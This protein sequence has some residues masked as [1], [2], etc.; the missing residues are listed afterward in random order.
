MNQIPSSF[1]VAAS[2][3]SDYKAGSSTLA[4]SMGSLAASDLDIADKASSMEEHTSIE[5]TLVILIQRIYQNIDV[6]DNSQTFLSSVRLLDLRKR[7][8]SKSI[9]SE[10]PSRNEVM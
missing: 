7:V 1:A 3:D 4:A 5:S 2:A 9:N 6:T 10:H 8:L